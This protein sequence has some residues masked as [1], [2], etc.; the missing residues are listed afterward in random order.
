MVLGALVL[1][2]RGAVLPLVL[3]IVL[4][5]TCM[6]TAL[7]RMPGGVGRIA[8]REAERLQDIYDGE[9]AILAELSG[10]PQGYFEGNDWGWKLPE[11]T[12]EMRGP[13]ME[14]SAGNVRA[15][16]GIAIEGLSRLAYG[17]R[18]LIADG[19][20]ENLKKEILMAPNLQ[21]KSGNRRLFGGA[22]SMSLMVQ[23][24]DLYLDLSGH[25]ACGNF[26]STGSLT[27]RGSA[28]YDTLRLYSAGPLLIAGNISAS[29]LEAYTAAEVDFS[30]SEF[31]SHIQDPRGGTF[32]RD[33]SV[34]V[35]VAQFGPQGSPTVFAKPLLPAF[36]DGKRVPF[37]W[38][39][40]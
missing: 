27:L 1:R 17:Q 9:S 10:F 6:L 23:D 22:T 31:L 29:Y 11:V 5:V 35:I 24:G 32:L 36:I 40:Q 2:C 21:A 20:R 25:A 13:W 30:R 4:A 37:Q 18:K 19:L 3:G 15:L 38:S 7:L 8:L 14:Y 34:A 33:S 16:T 26:Y 39:L 12:K 28:R